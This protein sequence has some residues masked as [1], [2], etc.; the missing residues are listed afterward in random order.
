MKGRR[1]LHFKIAITL[2][3]L[4]AGLR[5]RIGSDTVIYAHDFVQCHDLFHL[6]LSD[7]E[8][9][10]YMPLWVLLNATCKTV[11]NDFV[12]VQFVI[13]TFSLIVSWYFIRKVCPSLQFFVLLC[14]YIGGR[15]TSL[16]MELL[17]ES[18]AVSFYLLG[19]LSINEKRMKCAL[20]CAFLSVMSHVFATVAI[21]LFI[22]CYYLLPRNN[23]LRLVIC[24]IVFFIVVFNKDF[25]TLFVQD[26]II[27]FPVKEEIMLKVLNYATSDRYGNIDRMS[28]NYISL[29][30]H[31]IVYVFMFYKCRN[32]YSKFILL[33]RD[34]FDTL[35]FICIILL[36]CKFS[37]GILYRIGVN[38]H[39]YF[40]CLLAVMFTKGLLI[41]TIKK[42]QRVLVYL[43][44]LIIPL[45]FTCRTYL[46]FDFM[47]DSI[48]W[49]SR[50]YPYSSVFDKTMNI[51]RERLHQ[52][53]GCG[54]TENED[55]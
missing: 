44:L 3:I 41:D 5:W 29:V 40:T 21:I 50:Y 34:L 15:F 49:Y 8:S 13:A 43:I 6:E 36:L 17:R 1:D 31:F 53:R 47:Y 18:I 45:V 30:M 7:F 35:I 22:I 24:V 16:N 39:Y 25:L 12:L 2:L 20:L 23:I 28:I 55:Y 10:T 46:V 19:I 52:Y 51:K 48:R 14:Y 27:L 42:K 32:I 11:W 33:R 54:Y 4:V 37:L 9:L 26:N 38:Y